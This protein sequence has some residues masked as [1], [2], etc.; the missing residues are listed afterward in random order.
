[1]HLRI[2]IAEIEGHVLAS[3]M[4]YSG[5]N[6]MDGTSYKH[7][8]ISPTK[9]YLEFYSVHATQCMYTNVNVPWAL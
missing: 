4:N 9:I 5:M 7:N 3:F 1:M 2:L 6:S 8:K